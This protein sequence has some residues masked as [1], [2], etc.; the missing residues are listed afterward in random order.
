MVN[1][2]GLIGSEGLVDRELTKSAEGEEKEDLI[3]CL[4]FSGFFFGI[5]Y[6]YFEDQT[7]L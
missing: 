7:A 1:M 3:R 6:L 4:K 5:C 2:C